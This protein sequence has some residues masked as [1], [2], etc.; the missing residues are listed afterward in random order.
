[1]D[2]IFSVIIPIYNGGSYLAD[3]INSVLAQSIG[4]EENIQLILVN[5]GSTDD[6]E[7]ICLQFKDAYPDNITYVYQDNAGVSAARN[8]GIPFACGKYVNFMD[9]DDI[10]EPDAFEL[11]YKMFEDA[12]DSIDVAAC[13]MDFFEAKSGYHKLDYKFS[14]GDIICDIFEHPTY[15]QYSVSSAFIRVS[16]INGISFDTRLSYGEDAK[17][18]ISLI[19]N[20]EKYGLL[21]SAVYHIRKHDDGSSLTQTK[22]AKPTAYADTATYYYKYIADLSVSKYGRVIPFIQHSLLNAIKFRVNAEIPSNIPPE[23]SVP[24][25]ELLDELIFLLDDEVICRARNTTLQTRLYF[26]A[27]KYGQDKLADLITLKD[28]YAYINGNKIGPVFG[29][30]CLIIESISKRLLKTEITGTIRCPLFVEDLSLQ[31]KC[32]KKE[33]DCEL[34]YCPSKNHLSYKG[35]MMNRM[36]DFRVSVPS[37][38]YR[39]AENHSWTVLACNKEYSVTP[40]DLCHDISLRS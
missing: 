23:I 36:Y 3:T 34:T 14:H 22:L 19:L 1:M 13:R 38:I 31:L 28:S 29:K 26:L 6:S 27:K 35:E 37:R 4:F 12:G 18:I 8:A 2:Y 30:R 40:E 7:Q 20:K 11:A 10:W 24:Y 25:T 5:D 9:S 33:F 16:A 21:K 15:G 17:F 32:G 39:R